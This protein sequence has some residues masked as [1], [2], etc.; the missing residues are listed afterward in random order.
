[1][2]NDRYSAPAE[3]FLK[4]PHKE[5]RESMYFRKKSFPLVSKFLLKIYA[6][7]PTNNY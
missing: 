6:R 3:E 7:L 1:M 5:N 4:N 2:V